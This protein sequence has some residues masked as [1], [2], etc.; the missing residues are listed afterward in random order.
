MVVIVRFYV[1]PQAWLSLRPHSQKP[2]TFYADKKESKT[3]CLNE[4]S[5][6]RQKKWIPPNQGVSFI[7]RGQNTEIYTRTSLDKKGRQRQKPQRKAQLKL[8]SPRERRG[9]KTRK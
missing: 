8:V 7:Y 5:D 3:E 6:L 1:H 2:G 9:E 4:S